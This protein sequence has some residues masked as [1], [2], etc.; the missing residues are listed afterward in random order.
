MPNRLAA[1][2][3]PY[4]RQ[5][6]D[7]PVDW[8]PW[9]GE[10]LAL[11]VAEQKPIFLSIGYSACH[12]CHVMAHESFEDAA[13]AEVLNR[14]F[15]PIKIDREERPDLDRVYMTYVQQTTG[16]GGWPMSVWLTPRGL[17]FYGGTYFP[18]S[19]RPGRLGFVTVLNA[20]T[21]HWREQR[22]KIESGAAEV[23]AA[24]RQAAAGGSEEPADAGGPAALADAAGAAFDRGFHSF[25]QA[26]DAEW[27]GF[28]GAPKFPRASVISFLFR[29]AALQGAQSEVGAAATGRAVRTLQK[30]AGGGLH[31]HVGGGFHRYSVDGQWHVPHFE[32]MLYDQAQIALNYLEARQATGREVF[33]WVARGIFDYVRR[34]LTGAHGGFLSAEDA[35]SEEPQTRVGRVV[36]DEP[37][38]KSGDAPSGRAALAL[39]TADGL[40]PPVRSPPHAEGAFYVWTAEE[41]VAVLG[42]DAAFFCAHFGVRPAGNVADDPSGEF[43]GRNVLMQ[44]QSLV[45]TAREFKR[46]IGAASGLLVA[47]LEKLRVAR[48]RRPRPS[49]DDKVITAWNGLMI[50]A[51]AQG[52]RILGGAPAPAHESAGE[53]A[54]VPDYLEQATRAAKFLRRELYDPTN[55]A[56]Y[57]SWREGRSDI[58][59]FAEDYACLIQ[60]LLDLYEVGFELR[61]LQWAEELQAAMDDRFWDDGSGGYFNSRADDP[62][63]IVRLKEDYDGAEP[64]PNSV[65]AMNLLRLDWM[66]GGGG[67][68]T[69]PPRIS[70]RERAMKTIEALRAQW[71][72]APHALPQMLCALELA[73]TE[74]RTVVLAGDPLA[75]DFQA[76]AAVVAGKFGPRRVVLAADGS[77][78][79]AWLAA[80]KSYLAD[81][82][83]VDGRATAYVCENF[84]CKAPVTDPADLR[85]LLE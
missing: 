59:G 54:A 66:L 19:D 42:D 39:A 78:G 63:V 52:A 38:T 83:P 1:E 31:D 21:R 5:H 24:L 67:E 9:G 81:L 77:V 61:W 7:N 16:H 75:A 43:R 36:P 69:P 58:V 72:R 25:D 27:G 62:T 14:D 74:P 15:V 22:E 60:G 80:H 3:S 32:K 33:A 17:P 46:E 68:G 57:R 4:L 35:D 13:V 73:L 53:V 40:A 10:A 26:F 48:D 6:A 11:A 56:L 70:Y 29:V 2:K 49:R 28:G 50:S 79:Q 34:D 84:T 64:A 20:I 41:I 71:T 51:L 65:A 47:S 45:A 23:I 18:P 37:P 44:Q 30:M 12:W 55:G 8:R 76:L 82:R 85:R